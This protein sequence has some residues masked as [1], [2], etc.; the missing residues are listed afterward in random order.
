MK[1]IDPTAYDLRMYD[2]ETFYT[3]GRLTG[4]DVSAFLTKQLLLL[5]SVCEG[6]KA[7][8]VYSH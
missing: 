4:P 8:E 5:I 6:Q 2:L 1:E 3:S 7:L